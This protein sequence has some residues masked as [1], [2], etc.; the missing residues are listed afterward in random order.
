MNSEFSRYIDEQFF[1]DVSTMIREL[2][3]SI[4]ELVLELGRIWVTWEIAG[5][6]KTNLIGNFDH[7]STDRD[8]LLLPICI[9]YL[10]V[11][12]IIRRN[13]LRKSRVIRQKLF[14]CHTMTFLFIAN[15]C[16]STLQRLTVCISTRVKHWNWTC[17]WIDKP[18]CRCFFLSSFLHDT[19]RRVSPTVSAS[20]LI[21]SPN[22]Q[23]MKFR[24]ILPF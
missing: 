12:Y 5:R 15:V 7:N 18:V 16:S 8:S 4:S 23:I 1:V 24:Y 14:V 6:K 21:F 2:E 11:I 17:R 20:S 3:W 10:N 13:L 22:W 9:L 19:N